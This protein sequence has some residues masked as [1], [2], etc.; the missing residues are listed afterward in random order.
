MVCFFPMIEPFIYILLAAFS[1]KRV[2]YSDAD[3]SK[4]EG[5]ERLIKVNNVFCAFV[6]V[7]LKARSN[8]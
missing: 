5:C 3:M 7:C 4:P 6:A 1:K 2:F 8:G